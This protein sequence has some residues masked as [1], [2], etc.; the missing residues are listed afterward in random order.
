MCQR[1]ALAGSES[2]GWPLGL[3][4]CGAQA[5]A[6]V[7]G[8]Q[9]SALPGWR[10]G[11]Y[12]Q[13]ESRE[14][15]GTTVAR[16][17]CCRLGLGVLSP[18]CEAQAGGGGGRG[19]RGVDSPSRAGRRNQEGDSCGPEEA[20]SSGAGVVE[21]GW[22]PRSLGQQTR[23]PRASSGRGGG[24][25]ERGGAVGGTRLSSLKAGGPG[26]Q[27]AGGPSW[28]EDGGRSFRA[29]NCQRRSRRRGAGG[30]R[31]ATPSGGRV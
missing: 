23:A 2:E 19:G 7:G 11:W 30:E 31:C 20:S 12:G 6:R 8:Q 16:R 5:E 24:G 21:G 17:Q 14:T 27:G 15:V 28:T 10:R 4:N 18:G 13:A 26:G 29:R 1:Q 9:L 3:Q 22:V 25:G